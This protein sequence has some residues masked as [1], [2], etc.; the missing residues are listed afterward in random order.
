MKQRAAMT[1]AA[2]LIQLTA[3][4]GLILTITTG[5]PIWLPLIGAGTLT[6]IA[7]SPKSWFR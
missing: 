6:A 1:G 2:V 7:L 5:T 3:I 4:G